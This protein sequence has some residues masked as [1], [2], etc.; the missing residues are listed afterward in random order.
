MKDSRKLLVLGG[1]LICGAASALLA[2]GCGGDDTTPPAGD[3]GPDSTTDGNPPDSTQG[4]TQGDVTQGDTQTGDVVGNDGPVG[5]AGDAAPEASPGDGAALAAFPGLVAQALCQKVSDCCFGPDAAAFDRAGCIASATPEGYANTLHGAGPFLGPDGGGVLAFN[6]ASATACIQDINS[7][8]CTA[9]ELTTAVQTSI[10]RDCVAAVYGT[11]GAGASCMATIECSPGFFCDLPLDGGPT[12][13]C[14]A[15]AGDGGS[16]YFGNQQG[17]ESFGQSEEA[18]SFRRNG[19][20]GLRCNNADPNT[21]NLYDGGPMTWT[22]APQG[23]LGAGCNYNQDCTTQ[24]CDPGLPDA[25]LYQCVNSETFI[26][27]YLC[28]GYILDAGGGG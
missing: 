2:G 27:P 25:A 10:L 19:L 14:T 8:D 11:L 23:A 12:G 24:L 26:Y 18:C 15:L 5:D 20:S 21:G 28:T 7:I 9:N 3:G 13:S 1:I 22:C 16:C 4:D 17:G 6:Q